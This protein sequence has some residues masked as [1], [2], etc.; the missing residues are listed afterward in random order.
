M[1]LKGIDISSWNKGLDY[2]KIKNNG[3]SFVM[4]RSSF[5]WFNEDNEFRNHVKGCEAVGLPYGLYHYSYALNLDQAKIEADGLINLAKSCNPTYPIVLDMEDADGYKTKHGFPSNETLVQICE[6]ILDRLEKAGFYAM[7]YASKSW[8]DTKLNDSRLN[9]FD[10]WL[11]HWGINQPSMSCGIWQYT[12]TGKV[13]GINGNVDMNIAYKDYPSIIKGLSSNTPSQPST[14]S[15]PTQ[16]TTYTV[17]A[18][19]TLSSIANKYGTT[20]QELAKINGISNPDL[21]YPGQVLKINSV[22]SQP[23]YTTYTVKS[24]DTL[25]SIAAKYGTTYQKIAADN[26]ISNP[27]L[28]YPGQV[29]V[30][31]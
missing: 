1:E 11:A 12:S 5:G 27:N 13:N 20:Y 23:S 21:I 24:G 30:I 31:K 25:S 26:G 4:I 14:P 22:S 17:K 15:Q 16:T 2:N 3:I 10:K 29:L 9:R 6:Y 8:F 7:L 28:I 19:D 18:G